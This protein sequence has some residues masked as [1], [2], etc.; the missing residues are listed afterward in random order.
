M[1]EH[2]LTTVTIEL[3][4]GS[5]Y[6]VELT[7]E[8]EEDL[9][10]GMATGEVVALDHQAPVYGDPSPTGPYGIPVSPIIGRKQV[11]HFFRCSEI[12]A[13]VFHSK[14]SE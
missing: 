12:A 3:K 10:K 11:S 7:E 5:E 4:S 14:E 6:V 9:V 2:D 8:F 1:G 13:I